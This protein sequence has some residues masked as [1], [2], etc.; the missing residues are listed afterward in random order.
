MM[1]FREFLHHHSPLDKYHHGV[2]SKCFRHSV[3]F[4]LFESFCNVVDHKELG[5]NFPAEKARYIGKPKMVNLM[6]D[7]IFVNKLFSPESLSQCR[8]SDIRILP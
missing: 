4:Q 8:Y 1:C 2:E 7:E 5:K 3:S 6:N